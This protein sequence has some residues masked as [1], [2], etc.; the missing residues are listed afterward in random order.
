MVTRRTTV[1]S[2]RDASSAPVII[3]LTNV[4]EKIARVLS[5][6]SSMVATI[7][8]TTKAAQ[9]TSNCNIKHSHLF[10]QNSTLPRLQSNAQ[11]QPCVTYAQITKNLPP[12]TCRTDKDPLPPEP[13]PQPNDMQDLKYMFTRLS[14][15]MDNLLN[16]LTTVIT[17]L[18]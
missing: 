13:T 11:T 9:S 6:V 7:R 3:S 18:K 16:L 12:A 5:A 14:E 2:N 8:R 17:K 10:V 4:T 1:I 15:R